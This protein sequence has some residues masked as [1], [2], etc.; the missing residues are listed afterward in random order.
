MKLANQAP[1]ANRL[2]A[3]LPYAEYQNL[4]KQLEPVT[5]NFGEI[6]YESGE[7]I[8]E[9][10][11]PNDS[12]I[13]LLTLVDQHLALEVGLIGY[14]GLV[15]I[16]LALGVGITPFRTLVRGSGTALRIK[17]APFC[18]ELRQNLFLQR[19]INRYT[20]SLMTQMAQT[21]A[22]NR[23][24]LV[25]ARLAR[26]LLMTRD[27]VGSNHF[28]LTHDFLA[29]MLGVRRVGITNAAQDLKRRKLIDYKRGN[30]SIVDGIG[31]EA[32]S[33]SCYKA[34]KV[35]ASKAWAPLN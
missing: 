7:P 24:H 31:L 14:E 35:E 19:A 15:G 34:V 26:W 21:A 2:L 9:V 20:H 32:A 8:N 16:S 28:H 11:F 18:E 30:I 4:L 27:R 33:C 23:F 12:L 10:Y 25:E 13:S 1:I 17:A 5:L 29:N 22:C 3:A 6:L